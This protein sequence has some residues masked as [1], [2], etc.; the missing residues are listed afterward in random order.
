MNLAVINFDE[1]PAAFSEHWLPKIVAQMNDFQFKLVKFQEKSV[2]HKHDDT[3]ERETHH[4]VR[5]SKDGGSS[6]VEVG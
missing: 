3:F 4:V 5:V 6:R 2:W 1:K